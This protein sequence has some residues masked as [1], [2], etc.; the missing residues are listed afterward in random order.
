MSN[1]LEHAEPD[2]AVDPFAGLSLAAALKAYK[3]MRVRRALRS[4]GENQTLAAEQLG[5]KQSNLSRLMKNLG[6]KAPAHGGRRV[7][8]A[9]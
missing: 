1:Q 4:T 3:V 2:E 7:R 5:L 9:P 8:R 6:L